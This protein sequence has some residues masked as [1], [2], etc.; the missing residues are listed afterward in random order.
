MTKPEI[1]VIPKLNKVTYDVYA[2]FPAL[3][4]R[5]G[6]LAYATDQRILYYWNGA[7]WTAISSVE[8]TIIRKT[9][10]QQS[11]TG[12]TMENDTELL[13]PVVAN[14]IC[15]FFMW[16]CFYSWS[17]PAFKYAFTVPAGGSLLIVTGELIGA[18]TVASDPVVAVDGTT[19]IAEILVAAC[20][21]EV[22]VWGKYVG[23]ANAGNIQLQWAQNTTVGANTYVRA[24]SYIKKLTIN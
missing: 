19:P 15:E 14:E 12:N 13:I 7:A 20:D 16:L 11:T 2:D 18:L 1:T 22:F 23:A 24:N 17:D 4:N 6:D 9:A 5:T 21:R 3:G 8:N 10:D